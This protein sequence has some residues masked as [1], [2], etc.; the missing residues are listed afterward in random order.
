MKLKRNYLLFLPLFL[1]YNNSFAD[2]TSV[3]C[4]KVNGSWNWLSNA[5]VHGEWKRKVFNL[6][7]EPRYFYYFLIK[8]GLQEYHSLKSRCKNEIGIE[9][10]YVQPAN[11]IFNYWH[12]FAINEYEIM[13][14]YAQ[15]SQSLIPE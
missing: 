3:Y 11:S 15:T 4:I 6:D 2:E 1:I 13:Q 12:P 14:S 5:K 9:Y 7:G 8:N 10:E